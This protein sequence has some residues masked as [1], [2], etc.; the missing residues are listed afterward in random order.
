[1]DLLDPDAGGVVGPN[2]P[3]EHPQPVRGQGQSK[4]R[5]LALD[6]PARAPA[7]KAG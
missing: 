1:V 5:A 4:G 2:G 7:F 6:F 3:T